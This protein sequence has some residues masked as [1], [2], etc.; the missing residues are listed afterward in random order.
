MELKRVS[1]DGS[2]Y[3]KVYTKESE[4]DRISDEKTMKKELS[5]IYNPI[6]LSKEMPFVSSEIHKCIQKNDRHSFRIR[7]FFTLLALCH[8]VLTDKTNPENPNHIVYKAQSPDEAALVQAVKDVGFTFLSRVNDTI[9]LDVFGDKRRYELLNIM[10]FNSFR[11]RMSVIVKRPE[12]EI[13]LICKG[14]DSVILTRL[15][16]DTD[17]ELEDVTSKHLEEFA[18]DGLRTLCVAFRVIPQHEYDKWSELFNKAQKAMVDREGEVDRAA[19]MIEKDMTLVGVT[20]IED[21]LQD[22]VPESIAKLSE[23]GIKIWVLTVI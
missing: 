16:S 14:A 3:G 10:E 19:E 8:T 13:L 22:G 9:T 21:K 7:E 4:E 5:K 1:I 18:N 15:K 23:A 11:K 6:Y 2:I 12:G 17:P 20:A